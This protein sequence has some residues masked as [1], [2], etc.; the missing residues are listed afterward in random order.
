MESEFL[1]DDFHDDCWKYA[2]YAEDEAEEEE[3]EGFFF[4]FVFYPDVDDDG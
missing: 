2:E 1:A 4:L 3:K